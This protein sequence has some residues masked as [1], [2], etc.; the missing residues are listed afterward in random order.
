MGKASSAKKIRRVQQAGVSR[1]P[2]Q[3]RNLAYP[4]LIA[5]IVV[6]GLVLTFFARENRQ[7]DASVAPV[8]NRDHWHAA[9]GTDICGTF[10][11][12]LNDQGPDRLGIHTH[13][14]GLIHIH[15]FGD[16]GSGANATFGR[17]AEQVGIA[18][19]SDSFTMPD[20]TRYRNGDRC[21]NDGPEGRVVLYVWPPQAN[22]NTEPR[23][24]T[25]DL[26][27][28]RFTEDGMIL[29]LAFV[30]EDAAPQLPPTVPALANPIDEE[31][32]PGS[33]DG[34]AP[35]ATVPPV[36]G[37]NPQ[38]PDGATG[39]AVPPATTPTEPAENVPEG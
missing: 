6:I 7:A 9:F 18:L 34:E 12:S 5:G 21:P 3:R 20:G 31:P 23:V 24:V 39:G 27:N 29:T 1:A 32:I 30:P 33:V 8:A 13:A 36:Q 28:V 15:P 2:G 16:G 37:G 35:A 17:F 22:D 4:A 26:G 10:Q 14:D 25:R 11:D 19:G 38:T